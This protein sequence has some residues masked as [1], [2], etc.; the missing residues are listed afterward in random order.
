MNTQ[1]IQSLLEMIKYGESLDLAD[2][3]AEAGID[4]EEI[5]DIR[6]FSDVGVLTNDAGFVVKMQDGRKFFITIQ[7][8]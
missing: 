6:S 3:A 8:Q 1:S 7:E 5:Q 2:A 4:P